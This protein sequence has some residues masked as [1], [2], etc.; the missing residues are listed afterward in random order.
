MGSGIRWTKEMLEEFQ[1]RTQQRLKSP[2]SPSLR[3]KKADML[4]PLTSIEKDEPKPRK[5]LNNKVV[6]DG[7]EFDS[8][9]EAR[10]WA[11]LKLMLAAGEIT[12]LQRQVVFELAPA[13]RL[14]PDFRLKPAIRLIADFTYRRDGELIVEDTKSIA[15]KNLPVYRIKKHLLKTVHGLDVH[16]V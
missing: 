16:E 1:A 8:R 2:L 6:I 3:E 13:A 7:I 15:T 5:Y 14:A 4:T 12:D 9:K 11:V 10:R